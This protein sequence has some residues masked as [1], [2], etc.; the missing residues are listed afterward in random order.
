MRQ[1]KKVLL[2]VLMV[3]LIM[4]VIVGCSSK[5]DVEE[6]ISMGALEGNTFTND[7]FGFFV[8]IP[9][10]WIIA[11][12]EEIATITNAGKD[13][14]VGEDE[15]KEKEYDLSMEQTLNMIFAFKYPLS[16]TEGFNPSFLTMA[17][18]LDLLTGLTIKD[19]ADYLA[20]MEEVIKLTGMPYVFKEVYTENIGGREFH[21]LESYVDIGVAKII[22]KNYS[23]IINKYALVFSVS[24]SNEAEE[25]EVKEILNSLKFQ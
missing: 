17:E 15:E 5:R 25:M 12:E 24:Y 6:V 19:G 2:L 3:S 11:S 8:E 14:I 7:Y 4:S 21:V 10:E 23:A 20:N 16:Y 9:E 13:L 18:N 22:Q 1:A